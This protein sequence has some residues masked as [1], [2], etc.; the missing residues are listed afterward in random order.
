[1]SKDDALADGEVDESN[2]DFAL[3]TAEKWLQSLQMFEFVAAQ[4]CSEVREWSQGDA[5]KGERP[6]SRRLS[7]IAELEYVRSLVKAQEEKRV[8]LLLQVLRD[9][10]LQEKLAAAVYFR[11]KSLLKERSSV[12]EI[13]MSAKYAGTLRFGKEKDF[14]AGLN[15]A[16]GQPQ[17]KLMLAMQREHIESL[18]SEV[19]FTTSNY[20][21]RTCSKIEWYFVV[22]PVAGEKYC[23]DKG[24]DVWPAERDSTL[25]SRRRRRTMDW[26]DLDT[27]LMR[28]NHRLNIVGAASR[29]LWE[30]ALG[31]RLYTGPMFQ[32]Y[33]LVMRTAL[34]DDH[35]D[36]PGLR[37]MLDQVKAQCVGNKYTTTIH[38]INS[39]ILKLKPL[40]QAGHVYRGLHGRSIPDELKTPD[41][42]NVRGGVELGFLS[43]TLDRR[44][45]MQYARDSG[46]IFELEMGL[47]DR[48]ADLTWIS[49]YPHEQEIL[50][51]LTALEVKSI[52]VKDGAVVVQVRPSVNT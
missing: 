51:P 31:L 52:V 6:L 20:Q 47:I 13:E 22:D 18:D 32:K 21:I 35:S 15:A 36:E 40:T 38:V 26:D 46:T 33:N 11:G 24:L 49:Q 1:M 3:W 16:V 27:R 8:S 14:Y 4:L 37:M 19:D 43:T 44:V 10:E 28:K 42:N 39:G 34:I 45:A 29:L 2:D 5:R 7:A 30:E 23:R 9:A 12:E 25:R 17:P 48:G 50:A 41:H